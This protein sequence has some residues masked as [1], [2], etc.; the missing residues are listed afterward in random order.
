ME[1]VRDGSLRSSGYGALEL[2][3]CYQPYMSGSLV[4]SILL[5]MVCVASYYAFQ[6]PGVNSDSPGG[7]TVY[8]GQLLFPPPLL[9]PVKKLTTSIAP[10]SSKYF[11][12]A[13]PVPSQDPFVDSANTIPTRTELAG[14]FGGLGGDEGREEGALAPLAGGEEM[15]EPPHAFRPVE[16]FPH[17]VKRVEPRYPE[18]ALRA[19]MT[20][21]VF[22]NLWVDFMGRVHKAEVAK[23]ANPLLDSSA[24]E[25]ASQWIFTPAIMNTRPVSVWV[26]VPFRFTIREK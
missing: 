22:L 3:L 13:I 5:Q 26:T 1:W 23:G 21:T 20:G 6:Q 9:S 16:K 12:N 17:V 8:V 18:S 7:P 25:A 24:M 4:M 11:Q 15:I 10:R 2:K 14:I 19:G